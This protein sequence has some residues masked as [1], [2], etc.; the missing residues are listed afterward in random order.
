MIRHI[1]DLECYKCKSHDLA[2]R[3][4]NISWEKALENYTGKEVLRENKDYKIHFDTLVCM[5]CG[6]WDW[7]TL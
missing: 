1:E 6:N 3:F 5:K 7:Y 2:P 4:K